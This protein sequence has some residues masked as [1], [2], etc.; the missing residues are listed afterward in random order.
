MNRIVSVPFILPPMPCANLPNSSAADLV[1]TSLNRGCFSSQRYSRSC[2]VSWSRTALAA[3]RLRRAT[4]SAMVSLSVVWGWRR[5]ARTRA[6]M[7]SSIYLGGLMMGLG[8][9]STIFFLGDATINRGGGSWA[10]GGA[11]S[12]RTLG[13]SWVSSICCSTLGDFTCSTV[14]FACLSG[15]LRVCSS[16]R[17]ASNWASSFDC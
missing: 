1:H 7:D 2:P 17:R 10:V 16:C 12:K 9:G 11:S 5:H 4:R 3:S 15:P 14:L 13:T 8:C 6:A